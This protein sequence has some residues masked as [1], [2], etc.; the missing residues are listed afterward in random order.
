M[1][2]KL[3]ELGEGVYEAEAVRW[4]V[5]AGDAVKPGQTLLEVLTDKATMEGAAPFAGVIDK[6]L[7]EPGQKLAVGQAILQY[8]EKGTAKSAPNEERT[9][10]PAAS[11]PPTPLPAGG[12]GRRSSGKRAAAQAAPPGRVLA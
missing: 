7:V 11:S 8:Q 6:L 12:G 1:D 4:L 9:S 3:P 5:A 2:F 10:K